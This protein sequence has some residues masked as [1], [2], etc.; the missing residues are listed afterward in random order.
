V[1]TRQA[2]RHR[3]AGYFEQTCTPREDWKSLD[4][5]GPQLAE[6]ELRYQGGDYD[7]AAQVVLGIDFDYL[8]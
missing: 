4:D 3:A 2:L 1:F 8:M 7:T 6:F 5:L